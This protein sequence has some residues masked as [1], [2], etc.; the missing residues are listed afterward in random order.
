[1]GNALWTGVKLREIL[2]AADLKSGSLQLQ[3]EG[4]DR[5]KGP[6]GNGSNRFMKSL[7]PT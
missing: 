6:E 7:D 1:M 3:F 5:G 2:D 4:L